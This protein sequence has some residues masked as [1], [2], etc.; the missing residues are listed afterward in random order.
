MGNILIDNSSGRIKITTPSKN[1]KINNKQNTS[2]F[3]DKLLSLTYRIYADS[4]LFTGEMG[5][6]ETGKIYNKNK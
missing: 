5:K 1:R 4:F 3:Q 6:M 2:F